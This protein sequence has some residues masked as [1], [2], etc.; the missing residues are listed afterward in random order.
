MLRGAAELL[1]TRKP[2]LHIEVHTHVF[3]SLEAKRSYLDDLLG[4]LEGHGYSITCVE[5][6]K[7]VM[8]GSTELYEESHFYCV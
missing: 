7:A 4:L 5:T 1:R 6:G 2:A 8:K 3:D